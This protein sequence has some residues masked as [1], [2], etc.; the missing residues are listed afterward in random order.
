M[1]SDKDYIK[2]KDFAKIVKR[3][4]QSIYKRL[5][6]PN[7]LL[8]AYVKETEEGLKI[9]KSAIQEVYKV[10]VEPK[11]E[12]EQPSLTNGII[13]EEQHEE[14][15]EKQS[16]TQQVIDILRKELEEQRK[17]NEKK[18]EQIQALTE[19]LQQSLVMLS[20]EQ[21]LNAMNTQRI[22]QLE[23]PKRKSIFDLFKRKEVEQ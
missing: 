18:D 1:N 20:N 21:K 19:Q 15:K 13:E 17:S 22:L 5:S 9:H 23:K 14:H 10:E 8:K 3:T 11:K 12:V 16:A 2:V 7:N 6:K 4:E